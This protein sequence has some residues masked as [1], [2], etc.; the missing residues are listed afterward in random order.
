MCSYSKAIKPTTAARRPVT[1]ML[2]GVAAPVKCATLGVA[3][4]GCPGAG[5]AVA[6]DGA[7]TGGAPG[8]DSTAGRI[9]GGAGWD[10]AE[11]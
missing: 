11:T 1:G 5:G 10:G 3:G 7:G 4:E 2:A 6:W 9:L 8:V